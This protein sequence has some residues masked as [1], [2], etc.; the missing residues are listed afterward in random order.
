MSTPDLEAY[1][2]TG[3]LPGWFRATLGATEVDSH[4]GLIT[5]IT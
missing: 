3:A 1:A 4:E 5:D 2:Q